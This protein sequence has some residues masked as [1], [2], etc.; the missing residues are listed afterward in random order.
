MGCAVVRAC[1][2]LLPRAGCLPAHQSWALPLPLPLALHLL[3]GAAQLLGYPW[4]C[5]SEAHKEQLLLVSPLLLHH[6]LYGQVTPPEGALPTPELLLLL[7]P[8]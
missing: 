1:A 8:Q 6:W 3:L 4:A 7:L 5:D 2:R